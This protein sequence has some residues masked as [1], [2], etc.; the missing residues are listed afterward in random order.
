MIDINNNEMDNGNFEFHELDSG[1]NTGNGSF[2]RDGTMGNN[3]M[4]SA[5]KFD[6][7][8]RERCDSEF[9]QSV[10]VKEQDTIGEMSR[11]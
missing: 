2:A 5:R 4:G 9:S 3:M 7:I 6:G 8:I 11:N 10:D 1:L